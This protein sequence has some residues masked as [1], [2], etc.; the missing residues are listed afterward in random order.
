MGSSI[1]VYYTGPKD[2]LEVSTK[3]LEQIGREAERRDASK[4]LME[5]DFP[6][7]V[8]T[9]EMHAVCEV[10]VKALRRC[11]KVAHVDRQPLDM[12]LNRFGGTVAVNRR[13]QIRAFSTLRD[14][15]EWLDK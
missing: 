5:E 2:S 1:Y 10:M 9:T 12:E 7:Q 13:L 6:N 3:I 11:K 15:E 14:A 4:V 8:T